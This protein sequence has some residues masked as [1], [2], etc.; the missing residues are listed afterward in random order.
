MHRNIC[1]K[2]QQN[3]ELKR[4]PENG[5]VFKKLVCHGNRCRHCELGFQRLQRSVS[6][7]RAGGFCVNLAGV[8]HYGNSCDVWVA[9]VAAPDSL[10]DVLFE[11]D[12]CARLVCGSAAYTYIHGRSRPAGVCGLGGCPWRPRAQINYRCFLTICY[13]D[14]PPVAPYFTINSIYF[15][16]LSFQS[17]T[18]FSA[19]LFCS[20]GF[21]W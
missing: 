20:F 3:R 4:A 11:Y 13:L 14:Y 16:P 15:S 19:F 18:S 6:N 9:S 8:H 17:W 5:V 1:D 10:C 7:A 21:V 12:A 2:P